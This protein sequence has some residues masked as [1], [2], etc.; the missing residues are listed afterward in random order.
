MSR[1]SLVRLAG[2]IAIAIGLALPG[3]AAAATP[4]EPGLRECTDDG[5]AI[6]TR[7]DLRKLKHDA[8][9]RAPAA[10]SAPTDRFSPRFVP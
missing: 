3:S 10:V 1:Q 5:C 6:V 9:V 7:G 4:T 2:V 8:R